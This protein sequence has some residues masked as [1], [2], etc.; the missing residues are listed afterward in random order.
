MC[1]LAR[2]RELWYS[3]GMKNFSFLKCACLAGAFAA[4]AT[5]SAATLDGLAAKVNDD[6]ITIDEV[7]SELR[8]SGALTP[9]MDFNAAYSNAVNAVIDRRLILRAAAEHKVNMQE[10]VV[11]NR[12]REIVKDNFGNDMTKLHTMLAQSRMDESDWRNQIRDEMVV[13]AMRYQ[14]I[15][16]SV[17]AA[18]AEMQREYKNHPERYHAKAQS[19]VSVILLRPPADDK[20]PSLESRAREILDRLAKGEEFASLAKTFSADSHAKDG[21][22]WTNI[23]PEESFRPEIAE[24]IK[25]LKIGQISKLINL[26]GW[27]FIV[28]KVSETKDSTRSF[29]DAYEDI[30]RNV[31]KEKADIK[32]KEWVQRLR[33]DAFLKIHPPPAAK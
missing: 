6:V 31:K 17:E 22:L 9:D 4:V 10:W 20:Q 19:T 12:I 32:Y 15:E 25:N 1:V 18:P 13:Q 3:F 8:R 2:A 16:K 21:G 24:V 11:D 7:A 28:R 23:N 14:L 33:A 30:A 26:D 5:V 29:A 27:G